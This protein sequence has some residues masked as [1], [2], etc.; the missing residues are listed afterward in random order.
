[1][2]GCDGMGTPG[3][4]VDDDVV[5]AELELAR[6]RRRKE[7]DASR[8]GGGLSGGASPRRKRA[9]KARTPGSASSGQSG[10][11]GSPL[12]ARR[13]PLDGKASGPLSGDLRGNSKRLT[14]MYSDFVDSLSSTTGSVPQTP[15][16]GDSPRRRVVRRVRKRVK[17]RQPEADDGETGAVPV[18]KR[19]GRSPDMIG[20]PLA[21]VEEESDDNRSERVRESRRRGGNGVVGAAPAR[22]GSQRGRGRAAEQAETDL[23]LSLTSMVDEVNRNPEELS[24][25]ALEELSPVVTGGARGRRVIDRGEGRGGNARSADRGRHGEHR[26]GRSMHRWKE[27]GVERVDGTRY[28]SAKGQMQSSYAGLHADTVEY[29]GQREGRH[30]RDGNAASLSSSSVVKRVRRSDGTVVQVRRKRVKRSGR[31]TREDKSMPSMAGADVDDGRRSRSN[32]HFVKRVSSSFRR[33]TQEPRRDAEA[34]LRHQAA[35]TIQRH[36]RGML[37][38][39]F[40]CVRNVYN[41]VSMTYGYIVDARKERLRVSTVGGGYAPLYSHYVRDKAWPG[42]VRPRGTRSQRRRARRGGMAAPQS[43]Q[44]IR[45]TQCRYKTLLRVLHMAQ[46]R[47]FESTRGKTVKRAL[48]EG[49]SMTLRAVMA[50]LNCEKFDVSWYILRRE[51]F[52]P[53][54]RTAAAIDNKLGR[55]PAL[56]WELALRCADDTGM[57]GIVPSRR[58]LPSRDAA[59]PVRQPENSRSQGTVSR[60]SPGGGDDVLPDQVT[61]AANGPDDDEDLGKSLDEI[62]AGELVDRAF[63]VCGETTAVLEETSF[64]EGRMPGVDGGHLEGEG[65]VVVTSLQE[66]QSAALDMVGDEV[67]RAAAEN[68]NHP[69]AAER[70]LESPSRPTP[71]GQS[72]PVRSHLVAGGASAVEPSPSSLRRSAR[73]SGRD[74]PDGVRGASSPEGPD[75][76]QM[77][78]DRQ[79]RLEPLV[80]KVLDSCRVLG[81]G[82]V[83][84]SNLGAKASHF[85]PSWVSHTSPNNLVVADSAL[86]LQQGAIKSDIPVLSLSSSFFAAY[87]PVSFDILHAGLSSDYAQARSRLARAAAKLKAQG[88]PK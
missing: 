7:Y 53:A 70:L 82:H 44:R 72:T 57:S 68:G 5:N 75:H 42:G 54:L 85:S 69:V 43:Q 17:R 33:A 41:C 31:S 28:R 25:M 87:R 76:V 62:D 11:G 19:R 84:Q 6:M 83:A 55:V 30:V 50:R 59:P 23:C 66:V 37:A 52:A 40:L 8:G 71:V 10:G 58:A 61:R 27:D 73:T 26:Q 45:N 47:R 36:F 74:A 16:S 65:D 32:G 20:S 35:T 88:A 21:G 24:M 12:R 60:M 51:L 67:A 29:R 4:T 80:H 81:L 48:V 22:A 46:W 49:T 38:R 1:M 79:A 3:T 13:R 15:R 18:T 39:S 86:F 2:D 77:M 78:E 14:A 34:V 9:E 64:A 56:P 63:E